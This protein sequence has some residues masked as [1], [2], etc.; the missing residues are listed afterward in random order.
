MG[1]DSISIMIPT[2]SEDNK[3]KAD[4]A[5]K[6]FSNSLKQTLMQEEA[7]NDPEKTREVYDKEL[8]KLDASLAKI[9]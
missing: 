4:D 2:I 7:A 8:D 5:A 6:A 3:S 9:G 1:T